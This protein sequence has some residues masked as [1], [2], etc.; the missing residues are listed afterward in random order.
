MTALTVIAEYWRNLGESKYFQGHRLVDCIA[1]IHDD[2]LKVWNFNDPSKVNLHW[3]SGKRTSTFIPQS[4]GTFRGGILERDDRTGRTLVL[5]LGGY[6]EPAARARVSSI[7]KESSRHLMDFLIGPMRMTWFLSQVQLV[8][9]WF[10]LPWERY[11]EW[12]N[13]SSS[14]TSIKKGEWT[15]LYAKITNNISVFCS[16]STATYLAA[17]IV[18]LT[19]VLY[20]ISMAVTADDAADPPRTL[21]TVLVM[22]ALTTY[23]SRSSHIHTQVK[24]VTFTLKLEEKI[25]NVIREAL[26]R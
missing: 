18:D 17:Y 24:E 8:A 1:R 3:H 21:S 9:A 14:A 23:K 12:R 16:V 6:S 2:V 4:S 10:F 26:P 15:I 11:L 5:W 22:D 7:A 20:E 19:L 25:A 13:S